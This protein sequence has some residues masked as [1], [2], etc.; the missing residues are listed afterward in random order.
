MRN[1]LPACRETFESAG[2][3]SVVESV[4]AAFAQDEE[5]DSDEMREIEAFM[6]EFLGFL[7]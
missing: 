5:L 4:A 2:V 3:K 7:G 6:A 1:Q